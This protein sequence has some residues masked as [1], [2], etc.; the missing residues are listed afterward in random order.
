MLLLL[1]ASTPT[2]ITTVAT[3]FLG[4]VVAIFA[5][6]H[7]RM[8]G[9]RPRCTAKIDA[10]RQAMLLQVQN[11][12]RVDGEIAGI[13]LLDASG[14]ASRRLLVVEGYKDGRFEATALPARAVMRLIIKPPAALDSFP[15]RTYVR[16]VWVTGAKAI[17]PAQ[18][19]GVDYAG[20]TSAL[21]LKQ[22]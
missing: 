13:E 2:W 9:F 20:M 5:V 4:I 11:R 22:N 15:P 12:G 1:A 19:Y 21:P 17:S 6:W 10:R 3:A 18:E 7:V 14:A 16:V 8:N